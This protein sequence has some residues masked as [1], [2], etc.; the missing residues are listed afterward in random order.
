MRTI[1]GFW[2]LTKNVENKWVR[3]RQK[4]R[5]RDRKKNGFCIFRWFCLC[6]ARI[7]K[8]P[9]IYLQLYAHIERRARSQTDMCVWH[10]KRHIVQFGKNENRL[11]YNWLVL[12]ILLYLEIGSKRTGAPEL[13]E[14]LSK[15][16]I[17][18]L[19]TSIAMV[20]SC[21]SFSLLFLAVLRH[22]GHD[23]LLQAQ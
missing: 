11:W 20:F 22:A 16:H 14:R 3:E 8:S 15:R 4:E 6:T 17:Y 19:N 2:M 13:M 12:I 18:I 10:Y 23:G 7:I 1:Y 21:F 9:K 5:E